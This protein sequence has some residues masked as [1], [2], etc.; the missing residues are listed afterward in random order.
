VISQLREQDVALRVYDPQTAVGMAVRALGFEYYSAGRTRIA[1]SL[2][3]PKRTEAV[4]EH[5]KNLM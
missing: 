4:F 1:D 3:M 5:R 2:P